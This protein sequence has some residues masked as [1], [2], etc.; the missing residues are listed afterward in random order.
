METIV[1]E[2]A[3]VLKRETD[4]IAKE[5][6]VVIFL[7]Q[8]VCWIFV[9]ALQQVD[10]S[11]VE[12]Q[13]AKGYHIEKKSVRTIVTTFGEIHY[14]RRRFINNNGQVRYPLDTLMGWTKY[15]RYSTLVVRNLGELATKLTYRSAAKA[16]ELF[17]PF[18][19]S[20]Q[21]INALVKQAGQNLK[22]QQ[23][24][25]QRYD[26][27]DQPKR[28]PKALYLEGDGFMIKT[29]GKKYLEVHRFQVCEGVRPVGK[30]RKERLR[31]RDFVSLNRQ[32][33]M[34]ELMEYLGNT[35]DLKQTVVISNGDGG[36]GYTK[37]VFDE[38]SGA[39]A[40]HEFF[41]DAFHVNKKIKDRLYFAKEL[42]EPLMQAI[43]RD[44]SEE[45]VTYVLDT[46]DSLLI[47]ELDTFQ[48]R[49]HLRK[50][51]GYLARNWPHLRPFHQR[52]LTGIQKAIGSC[53]SNHRQY[54]Y[55]MK[56]QGKYWTEKGAEAM[57]RFIAS[58]K[59]QDLDKWMMTEY[60]TSEPL[61]E[62]EKRAKIALRTAT[63]KKWNKAE[64]HIGAHPVRIVGSE[65]SSTGMSKL[66]RSFSG[67]VLSI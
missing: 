38:L 53:E 11:L 64:P 67:L 52:Q 27:L 32:T 58:L 13:K 4:I 45:R 9:Q 35:Y 37:D 10:D 56:G 31:A 5:K 33:A 3:E 65:K 63:A 2:L 16:I 43:W 42:H 20:H 41:L 8:V 25:D 14:T 61:P 46:A 50:L 28:A 34:K 39:T 12:E 54:T 47:G 40:R 21:K 36:S 18:S 23:T 48:N 66:A 55:R 7:M 49:E 26:A 15:S 24:S 60:E 30:N 44:Y 17:A 62:F 6:A 22:K 19:I 59:N 1:N 29:W 57:V 51:R